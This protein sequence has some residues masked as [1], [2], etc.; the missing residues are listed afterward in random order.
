MSWTRG[1]HANPASLFEHRWLGSLFRMIVPADVN[2][3]FGLA[4]QSCVPIEHNLL[5]F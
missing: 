5:A 3:G 4:V 2:A 1:E